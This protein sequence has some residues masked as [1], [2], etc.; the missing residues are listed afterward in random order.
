MGYK[1][2][3]SVDEM[4]GHVEGICFI[5]SMFGVLFG[6]FVG[7][8]WM[9]LS[10][11]YRIAFFVIGLAFTYF[12]GRIGKRLILEK[13]LP[14]IQK[15]KEQERRTARVPLL[16]ELQSAYSELSQYNEVYKRQLRFTEE[17]IAENE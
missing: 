2:K 1:G 17:R 15:E 16:S 12:S 6:L 4:R 10:M 3:N 11:G 14:L 7:L 9:D 8:M 5:A 13:M